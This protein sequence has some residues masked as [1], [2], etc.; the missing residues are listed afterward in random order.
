MCVTPFYWSENFG[1]TWFH[2]PEFILLVLVVVV[3]GILVFFLAYEL[4][5]TGGEVVQ[6]LLL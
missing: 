5:F 6:F 4:I 3:G 2:E 1:W